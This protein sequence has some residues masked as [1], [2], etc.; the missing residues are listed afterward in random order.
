M[1]ISACSGVSSQSSINVNLLKFGPESHH[2][3]SGLDRLLDFVAPMFAAFFQLEGTVIA[4]AM[5]ALVVVAVVI[6]CVNLW[7]E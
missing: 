3:I 1:P 4:Q 5:L 7:S 6:E 2:G